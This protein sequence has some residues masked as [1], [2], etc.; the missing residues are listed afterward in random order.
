MSDDGGGGTTRTTL[1]LR[2]TN[3]QINP[4]GVAHN[5]P[6]THHQSQPKLDQTQEMCPGWLA[7]WPVTGEFADLIHWDCLPLKCL[8]LHLNLNKQVSYQICGQGRDGF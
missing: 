3:N 4:P 6:A 1:T 2:S 7:G 8:I 5:S